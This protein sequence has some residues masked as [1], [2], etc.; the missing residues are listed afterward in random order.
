MPRFSFLPAALVLAALFCQGAR[1]AEVRVFKP[2]EEGMTAMSLRDKAQAE[3]FAQA[4][5]DAAQASLPTPLDEVRAEYFREYLTGRAEPYVQGYKVL[6]TEASAAGLI[7]RM[8][9]TVNKAALRDGL[10]KLGLMTTAAHPVP[11]S[12]ALPGDLDEETRTALQ[13]MVVLTGLQVEPSGLP[14]V[15]LERAK[16]KATYKARLETG[17]REWMAVSKDIPTLWFDLWSHYFARESAFAPKLG[18]QVL[19]VTGWF[20]PD[21]VLEFDRVLRGWDYAVQ[22]VEMVEM[23]M[24]PAGVGATWTFRLLDGERLDGLLRG[25]LPQRGL[26]YR[27]LAK[28]K[29]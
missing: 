15:T 21:A 10:K 7:L 16:E 26:S 29:G 2:M 11:V 8:D 18:G 12:L 22:D 4:V 28:D 19:D 24:Q 5:L 1:A 20:S 13:H 6:A 17:D 9:V 23:D 14:R 3:G 25:F 27:L